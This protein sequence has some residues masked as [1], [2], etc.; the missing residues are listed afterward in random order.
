L[1]LDDP[2]VDE[3]TEAAAEAFWGCG[4]A[5][6]H[7]RPGVGDLDGDRP[8]VAR[9]LRLRQ[10]QQLGSEALAHVQQGDFPDGTLRLSEAL[11]QC[12]HLR[13]RHFWVARYLCRYRNAA[14]QARGG[15]RYGDEIRFGDQGG[16]QAHRPEKIAWTEF[17]HD[18]LTPA[19]GDLGE[20]KPAGGY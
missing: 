1:R 12:F 3:S 20:L 18:L 9:S 15:F 7:L 14:Q 8:A 2:L 11:G 5:A 16:E 17:P 4:E 19:A 13:Q 10:A 6:G